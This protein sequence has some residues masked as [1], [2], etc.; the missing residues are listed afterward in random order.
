MMKRSADEILNEL[1]PLKSS[2]K[3]ND[4]WNEFMNFSNINQDNEPNEESFLT[5]FDNLKHQ[6]NLASSTM[7]SIYSMLNHKMQMVYGQKLQKYP[8]L[9]ALL[10]SYEANY[11]RKTAKVFSKEDFNRFL[12]DAPDEGEFVHI[13][14]G[15]VIAFCG[16]LRC[17]D[18][19]SL[20]CEDFEFN[21]LTGMWINYS[22]SKNR[23]ELIR[24]KFNVPLEYCSYLQAYDEKLADC[25]VGNG[26]VFKT[27]RLK[28]DGT[29]Y[30]INQPMG[31][32]LISKFP[33]KMAEFLKLKDSKLYTGHSIRR[34]SANVL[35]EAGTT[36]EV[37]Q[38][39]F[40]WK[41]QATCS[42][43]TDRTDSAKLKISKIFGTKYDSLDENK[44]TETPV[45]KTEK[46]VELNNCQNVIINL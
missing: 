33:T 29:G 18:L 44:S 2:K 12:K 28:K 10:K 23:G 17:A 9:T 42:K 14:A 26:R 39:N 30:Y 6:K 45:T 19:L 41:N 46:S 43:Y 37:L 20:M 34:S 38:K 25:G 15:I 3:Y 5:Y 36:T 4:R 16:G 40:N 1:N 21:Q 24:N 31:I 22:V 35:A 8:R 32:H 13:K 27:F 11:V 7:W